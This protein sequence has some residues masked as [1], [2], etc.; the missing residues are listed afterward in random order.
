M[1]PLIAIKDMMLAKKLTIRCE[2]WKL[3]VMMLIN[4]LLMYVEK[5][6]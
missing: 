5:G 1:V 3:T 6:F 4:F 2:M